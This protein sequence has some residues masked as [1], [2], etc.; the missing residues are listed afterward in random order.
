MKCRA[1][2]LAAAG[3]ECRQIDRRYITSRTRPS[4]HR[5]IRGDF[6]VPKPGRGSQEL[7]ISS[8]VV[9][10]AAKPQRTTQA[11]NFSV[12]YSSFYR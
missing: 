10:V 5:V 12:F 1:L 6:P 3:A 9:V 4:D 8:L 7:A 2:A 11:R